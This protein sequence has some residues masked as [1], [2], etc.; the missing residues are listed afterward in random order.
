MPYMVKKSNLNFTKKKQPQNFS[1]TTCMTFL[2]F[3][4]TLTNCLQRL[5]FSRDFQAG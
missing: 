4:K 5:F 2:Q 1:K 3:S